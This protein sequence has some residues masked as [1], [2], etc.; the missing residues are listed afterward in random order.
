M[1]PSSSVALLATCFHAGFLR[2]LFFG[3]ED[4]G[5]VLTFDMLHS[6]ISQKIEFFIKSNLTMKT[7]G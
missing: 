5:D 1:A 6:V 4:G 7:Q 3:Y 2:G